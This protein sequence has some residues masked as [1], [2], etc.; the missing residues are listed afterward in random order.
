LLAQSSEKSA[1]A[2]QAANGRAP[3]EK[4]KANVEYVWYHDGS[5]KE[6]DS[7]SC[8]T[9]EDY[10]YLCQNYKGITKHAGSVATSSWNDKIAGHL[11]ENGGSV[12]ANV[13]WE[14]N[15]NNYQCRLL[16]TVGGMYQGSIHK[17]NINA[18]ISVFII[19]KNNEI[20]VHFASPIS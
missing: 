16:I 17:R 8:I 20:L 18:G 2:G 1:S 7:R 5:C 4:F 12:D 3:I 11:Y 9:P 13:T 14:G 19:N 15:R 10:Q 6:T